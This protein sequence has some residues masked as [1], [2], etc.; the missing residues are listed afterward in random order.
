MQLKKLLVSLFFLV[1]V[2]VLFLF[3]RFFLVEKP[4]E[5]LTHIPENAIFAMRLDG[6][7]ALKSTLFSILLEANDPEVIE[8]IN[9]QIEKKWKR[10]GV[11]KKL[12][13]DFLSDIV[14]YVFPFEGE[15]ILGMSYNLER[16]ELMRKNAMAA[17]D[18]TQCYAI[19][20][21][22]GIVLRYLGKNGPTIEQ[23]NKMIELAKQIALHPNP[24][25]LS[26][27]IAIKET[28]KFA[29]LTSRGLLYGTST[30]FTRTDMDLMLED[31]SLVLEGQLIKNART[32]DVFN[33]SNFTLK[34][35]GIHLYTNLI[36]KKVQDS[37]HKIIS[38][39]GLDIPNIRAFAINY[40]GIQINN[41]EGIL[42]NSPDMD[43][44]LNFE[45]T[46]DLAAALK[47]STFLAELNFKFKNESTI[48]NGI[49]NYYLTKI[50]S[51]TYSFSSKKK[52]DLK[53]NPKEC[54][55]CMEG[56][57]TN[58]TDIS[59]D[60][61]VMLF[62]NNLPFYYNSQSFLS[63][64]KG[65]KIMV[66]NTGLTKAKFDGSLDFKKEYYPMN[67]FFK[68]AIQNNFIRLK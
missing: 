6:S 17:L 66:T 31:H 42:I 2:W 10:K 14:V 64:T 59:G 13:I 37:L 28:D 40:R 57:L 65:V 52:I 27:K 50:D 41:P 58:L 63:K 33:N 39:V 12:G 30:L 54:L 56:E 62:L 21:N 25:D 24:S 7:S 11:S 5:N 38:K 47:K 15:Q 60:K 19:N 61:W 45:D 49:Q 3:G 35:S 16:P 22:I 8:V 36:P 51:R 53:R 44:I 4:I 23:R 9:K 48:T 43:L 68:Y 18:S 26:K 1:A 55:F 67:E 20:E 29:Q 46:V 34:P 32:K